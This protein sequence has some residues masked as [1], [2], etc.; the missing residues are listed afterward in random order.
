MAAGTAIGAL[1]GGYLGRQSG[2]SAGEREYEQLYADDNARVQGAKDM[3]NDAALRD[4]NMHRQIGAAQ[5]E[6]PVGE[7]R[8]K[9]ESAL[10]SSS[11]LKHKSISSTQMP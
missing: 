8:P 3:M 11:K 4:L 2:R 6:A 7:N 5:I 9:R 10:T 1:G